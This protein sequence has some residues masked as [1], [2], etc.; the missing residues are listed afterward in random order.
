MLGICFFPVEDA[1]ACGAVGSVVRNTEPAWDVEMLRA[2]VALP[3]GLAAE[4]FGTLW[5]CT[6]IRPFVSFLMLPVDSLLHKIPP[7]D[8]W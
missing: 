7:E 6:S 3:V 1:S 8:I 5:E 4:G 2:F